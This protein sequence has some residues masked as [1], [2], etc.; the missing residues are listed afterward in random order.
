MPQK[1]IELILLRQW[2]DLLAMPIFVMTSD[3]HYDYYNTPAAEILGRPFDDREQMPGDKLDIIFTTQNLD[4]STLEWKD[5]PINIARR[6]GRPAHLPFRIKGLDGVWRE[7]ETTAFPITS[8]GGK[9]LGSV[10]IFWQKK[11]E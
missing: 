5:L 10:A 1:D 6:E 7:L 9:S 4:G 2:A 11:G 3:G 8:Q